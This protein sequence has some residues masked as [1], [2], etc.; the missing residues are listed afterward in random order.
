[1]LIVVAVLLTI[2]QALNPV[3]GKAPN[4]PTSTSQGIQKN[5]DS[6]HNPAANSS[7]AVNPV[8]PNQNEKSGS[9]PQGKD[10]QQS[11]R[12]TEFPGVSVSRDWADW[13]L[14]V[15][16]G[17]LVLA[18]FLG[19]HVAN[20]TLKITEIAA[21]AAKLTAQ[22]TK[23]NLDSFIES[24]RAWLLGDNIGKIQDTFDPDQTAWDFFGFACR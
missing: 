5:A 17:L 10:A 7:S 21:R 24:E 1:M 18:A 23:T 3:P 13:M 22:T 14:W 4:S 19:I 15:F 8:Q 11:V 2:V 9:S 6:N 20:R 12:I 16:S